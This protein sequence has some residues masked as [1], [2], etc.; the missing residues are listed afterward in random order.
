MLSI[1]PN[2]PVRDK[3]DYPRKME[4]HFPI[5]TAPTNRYSSC[6]FLSFPNSLIRAKNRFVKNGTANFDR[7][8]PTKISGPP[9]ESLLRW[10][11]V[12]RSEETETDPS[13]WIPI[14]IS[15]IFG[16]MAIYWD[17]HTEKARSKLSS[18]TDVNQSKVAYCF[19]H[20][21][22]KRYVQS[23]AA[24]HVFSRVKRTASSSFYSRLVGAV[25]YTAQAIALRVWREQIV[26]IRISSIVHV[27]SC[28]TET[29]RRWKRIRIEESDST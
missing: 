15:G 12:F 23:G 16:I 20:M 10:S 19:S 24:Y 29:E 27:E 22:E 2:R 28:I 13:I 7:N 6:Q 1:I 25:S 8:I 17:L 18:Q 9:P 11:R 14:E 4:G 21:R 5:Q 26:F 3:R